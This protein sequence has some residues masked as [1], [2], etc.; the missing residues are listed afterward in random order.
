MVICIM[1]ATASGAGFGFTRNPGA[2]GC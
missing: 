1:P 2:R